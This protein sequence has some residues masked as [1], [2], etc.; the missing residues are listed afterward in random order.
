MGFETP[1]YISGVEIGET[2]GC[3]SIVNVIASGSGIVRQVLYAGEVD[4]E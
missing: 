3:G 1:V 2:R 4:L